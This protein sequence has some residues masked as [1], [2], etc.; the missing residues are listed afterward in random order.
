MGRV[1][2][3]VIYSTS[4]TRTKNVIKQFFNN[5]ITLTTGISITVL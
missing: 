4:S 3:T 5:V 1:K 2:Q